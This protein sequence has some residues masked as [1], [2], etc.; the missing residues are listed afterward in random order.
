MIRYGNRVSKCV[1][2][3]F[4]AFMLSGPLQGQDAQRRADEQ[5]REDQQRQDEARRAE[6]QRRQQDQQREAERRADEQRREEQQRQD[7]AR[8][9]E[10]QRRQQDHQREAERRADEQRRQLLQALL[11]P[12]RPDFQQ[13]PDQVPGGQ[14][15]QSPVQACS[16]PGNTA[17]ATTPTTP[18]LPAATSP[19]TTSLEI[20]LAQPRTSDLS[21]TT[22]FWAMIAA[23]GSA[24][25]AYITW[26]IAH[27]DSLESARP[28]E[29]AQD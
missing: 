17:P 8:R 20:P 24:V 4:C 19:A 6:D 12:S 9:A 25:C 11:S 15:A 27:R 13:A 22:A 26:R 16:T 5:R 10:D 29:A 2:A 7:E 21:P 3:I 1:V 14:G 23:I 18:E 28:P